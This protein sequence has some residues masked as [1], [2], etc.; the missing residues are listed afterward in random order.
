MWNANHTQMLLTKEVLKSLPPLY[1]QEEKG[2]EAVVY[3]KFFLESWTWF[4]T[5]YDPETKQMF[6]FTVSSLCPEGE[7]G[8]WDMNELAT[9]KGRYGN[10]V[11]RDAWFKPR[12]LAECNP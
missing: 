8:Y 12:T 6:G 3:V 10:A 11:E 9:I 2:L 4:G 5:E 1:A 7:L